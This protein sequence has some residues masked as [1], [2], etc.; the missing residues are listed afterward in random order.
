VSLGEPSNRQIGQPGGPLRIL[1]RDEKSFP[2][3]VFLTEYSMEIEGYL[4]W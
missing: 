2:T 3:S 1:V 4:F